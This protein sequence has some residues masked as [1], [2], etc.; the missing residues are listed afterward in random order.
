VKRGRLLLRAGRYDEAS[1][2]LH[3]VEAGAGDTRLE[4]VA[5]LA[6][7]DLARGRPEAARV[8]CGDPA[9]L[10]AS[11]GGRAALEAA[12]LSRLHLGDAEGARACFARLA[13]LERDGDGGG[14]V[15]AARA[16]GL[17]GMV[18]HGAGD[19]DEA[20]ARYGE[21]LAG[22][23]QASDAHATAT[24]LANLGAIDVERGRYGE[25]LVRVALSARRLGRLGRT[26]EWA[27]AL[28]NHA[29]LL[30]R[31][32][33][34]TGA[35]ELL[36]RARAAA[37]DAGTD[38]DSHAAS[39]E[40]D[41]LRASGQPQAAAEAYRRAVEIASA[42]PGERGVLGEAWLGLAAAWRE[43]LRPQESA[44]AL[45]R[46]AAV[47]VG[48]AGEARITV[49]R[50][51][52]AAPGTSELVPAL[53]LACDRL[54]SQGARD[55]LWRAELQLNRHAAGADSTGALARAGDI[56]EEVLMST[57]DTYR[58]ALR[59]D[60]DARLLAA[61]TTDGLPPAAPAL[62]HG[63]GPGRGGAAEIRLRRLLAINKRLNSETRLPRL[64]E[65]IV[66][67]TIELCDAERGF[68]VLVD[69]RGGF[70]VRTAR[71]FSAQTIAADEFA[72]SRS[73]AE[74]AA[75]SG[76]PIVTVDATADERFAAK[77]SVSAM[78]L[79][80]VLAAP[81]RV[82]G[83]LVG[84]LY[85][86]HR[87]RR[88]AFSEDD[89]AAVLDFAEQAAIAID[90]AALAA[91]LRRQAREIDRI[92][93]ELERRVE[94]REAEIEELRT[95]VVQ[96]RGAWQAR[97]P[98]ENLI[99]RS[100]GMRALYALL[101]RVSP[102]ELPVVIC[103]E[104]GT[105]KELVARA[106]HA[107]GPRRDRAFV[108]EN[109]S[110]IPES[111]LES[112]LFG[113]VRGAFTGAD[114][115]RRGLF[116]VADGGT[117]FL[118]EIGE[119]SPGMQA[120]LLRVLQDGE[121]RRVGGEQTLR[122]RVRVVAASNRDLRKLVADGRF[123]EDLFYRLSVVRIDVPPL[124]ERREDIP[125]LCEHFLAKHFSPPRSIEPAALRAL[126]GHRWPGNVR[127]LEN[128]LLRAAALGD[129]PI[130]VADL[131]A[132]LQPGQPRASDPDDLGIRAR[133]EDLERDLI[134][135]ALQRAQGNQSRAARLL[136][137]SRFGLHKKMQRFRIRVAT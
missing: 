120:K 47:L 48:P 29:N 137:V 124:R 74:Q 126:G 72:L 77:R 1:A 80:S 12:G 60:A 30:A 111:L 116:E 24:F 102:T 107:N 87:L 68:L 66:D 53:R 97:T 7:I 123:R 49:E 5:L 28:L 51:R 41:L 127:E 16:A 38:I 64:L 31:L 114:R 10:P 3:P 82:K 122:S 54:R 108:S 36:D 91:E 129:G 37:R 105:G 35:R 42:R 32:G 46:A 96:H 63:A 44:E 109:C 55:L 67:T 98:Y 94:R 110:A 121:F 57:P 73:I 90:N 84:T 69:D 56:F 13:D 132:E 20:A 52:A 134:R 4:A 119:M 88:G 125:L 33:D 15:G 23:E 92:R 130:R 100:E 9:A 135:T 26:A 62:L 117:L 101:D 25:A 76:Q 40:G 99:G 113:H 59:R 39:I 104:S 75:R 17:L 95:E 112:I 18:A 6:R 85:V 89:V 70:A 93:R 2:A 34:A 118:D 78:R 136:G 58:D 83:K 115:D 103:G 14:G 71:N 50:A 61:T 22:A 45:R 81:L 8:R 106:L 19:L 65:Y 79:R 43:A 86:D 27:Q 11:A 21:A 133:V 131:P 128:V